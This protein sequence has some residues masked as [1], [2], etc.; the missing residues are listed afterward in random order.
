MYSVGLDIGIASVGYS[1]IDSK[2]GNIVE[3]GA[4]IYT[5]RDSDDNSTRRDNRGARRLLRRRGTRLNDAKVYLNENNFPED[6]N[7]I[8]M[9]PY[10]L[11]VK[12][13]S[14]KISKE[15]IHKVVLHILKKRGV[16]YLD[17]DDLE[18]E[19]EGQGFKDEIVKNQKLLKDMTPG[20]IQLNRLKE[21]GRVRSGIN[22]KG[23]YQLNIFSVDS[24]ADELN[25][26][27]DTQSKYYK[28]INQDFIDFFTKKDGYRTEAGL[29]YRKR[30]YYDGPGNENQNS[31]Y[32]RWADYKENGKPSENIFDQLIGKDI[33]GEIR[34]SNLGP[35][36][37]KYNLLN[38][39]NNLKVTNR[40]NEKL[41]TEEKEQVIKLLENERPKTFGPKNLAKHLNLDFDVIQGWRIDKNEKPQ[42]H[43]MKEYSK[44]N[45]IF[46]ENNIDISAVPLDI[47]EDAAS[48]ITLNTEKEAF[49]LSF[50]K[51]VDEEIRN[52]FV[53]NFHELRK[54]KPANSWHSFSVKTLQE[55]IPEL[56]NTSDEQNTILERFGYK[57]D[58]RSK[59]SDRKYLPVKDVLEEI[60]NPTVSKSVKQ[61]VN[62]FNA[63]IKKYGKDNI[64]YITVEMPRDKNEDDQKKIIK[65]IQK[66]N[67]NNNTKSK[68]YFLKKSGWTNEHFEER[69]RKSK[70]FASKLFYYY[71]QDGLCAYS[72]Q[73][74]L[75]EELTS[76]KVEIDHVIPLSISLDDSRNNKVLVKSF[77]NQN[78]GQRSPIQAFDEGA[79]LGRSKEEFIAWVNSKKYKKYKRNLL[80]EEKD[81][82]NPEVRRS[83]VARN[84]NDTRYSSRILLNSIQSFFYNSDTKVRIING[85]FTHTLRKKWTT[86]LKDRETHHHHAV[87]ASLIAVTP[88]VKLDRFEYYY[89]EEENKPYMVDSTTGEMISYREYKQK[90]YYERHN[91]TPDFPDFVEQL[92]PSVLYPKIKFS[93]QVD[94]K[95]NRKLSDDTIYSTRETKIL[96]GR[97]KNQR[98]VTQTWVVGTIKDIYT[99][100]GYAQFQ[101]K[102][103][104]LLMR[105]HDSKTYDKLEEIEKE[106]NDTVEIEDQSGKIKTVKKSPFLQYCEKYNVPGITKYAKRNNGPVIRKLKYKDYEL[107]NQFIDITKPNSNSESNRRVVLQ[108]IN[109]WRTD[110]YFSKEEN[111]FYLVGIKYADL[112]FQDGEYG[113][114]YEKYQEIIAS[115][116]VPKKSTYKFS[117]YRRSLISVEFD[118]DII[119]GLYHSRYQSKPNYFDMRP[120]EKIRWEDKQSIPIFGNVATRGVFLKG[121]K[122]NMVL[123]KYH[124]DYLGNVYE[125]QEETLENVFGNHS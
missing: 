82:F 87:D 106:F 32:G 77:A 8:N 21:S 101:K 40:E 66:N 54:S 17:E 2:T 41:T 105:E 80:L 56:L 43:S 1:V 81:I 37:Q 72:G 62:V 123:R 121:L 112:K 79:N 53:D 59:Y 99:P 108:S 61:T 36:A 18:A 89:N 48:L 85:S 10:E 120:L 44:W 84:L 4:R 102:R 25:R 38:D 70:R 115:E 49:D 31:P 51:N 113:I 90:D 6:K 34:A 111:K 12:S 47:I 94:S 30:P 124:V 14:E 78:K 16:S 52:F 50:T 19:N 39:L 11:R 109:P 71:E 86:Y 83:F 97:G 64:D 76:E 45:E 88:F 46:T 57:F 110:V 33:R 119:Y 104:S 75:P 67:E 20:E 122:A 114:P 24:Y 96:K 100:E 91:Y 26:I 117:L 74:I 58:L 3:L 116:K 73:H 60:Y 118:D 93:H 9:C 107:K 125:L 92:L 5:A 68:E 29:V 27:L 7:L 35:S 65:E 103:D 95:F 28:E 13:L 22:Q 69:V 55:L 23:E 42:M 98:E 63:L 15:E